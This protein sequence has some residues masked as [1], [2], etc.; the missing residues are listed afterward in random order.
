[1]WPDKLADHVLGIFDI[2]Y[3]SQNMTVSHAL[4]YFNC[5]KLLVNF[6]Y[7]I[8]RQ[9]FDFLSLR[10]YELQFLVE[11]LQQKLTFVGVLHVN[12]V[13]LKQVDF[14]DV[15]AGTSVQKKLVIKINHLLNGIIDQN[16][17]KFFVVISQ[18]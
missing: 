5:P 1:M 18:R 14:W 8:S 17:M 2:V 3:V 4:L 13:S 11:Y 6:Y 12:F 7:S 10:K 9:F 16:L 15:D